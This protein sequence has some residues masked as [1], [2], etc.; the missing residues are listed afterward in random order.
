MVIAWVI[1]LAGIAGLVA[2]EAVCEGRN[3]SGKLQDRY[4]E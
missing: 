4:H 2:F 3:C 1:L